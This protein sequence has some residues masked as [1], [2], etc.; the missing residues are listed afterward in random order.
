ME[1]FP[2]RNYVTFEGELSSDRLR[3]NK[4]YH[5][6]QMPRFVYPFMYAKK[7]MM[8]QET[9]E[10]IPHI[11]KNWEI[12]DETEIKVQFR[13][14][15]AWAVANPDDPNDINGTPVKPSDWG[16]SSGWR[17]GTTSRPTRSAIRTPTANPSARSRPSPVSS[18]TTTLAR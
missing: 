15:S 4:Y 3:F 2:D 17:A 14:D 11:V 5:R 10:R 8:H 9:A 1:Q 18:S 16:Y 6:S 7:T 13:D 12:V